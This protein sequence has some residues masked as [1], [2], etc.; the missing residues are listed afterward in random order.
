MRT[1]IRTKSGEI[2]LKKNTKAALA[3]AL[4]LTEVDSQDTGPSVRRAEDYKGQVMVEVH[5]GNGKRPFRLSANKV[6]AVRS[7]TDEQLSEAVG[8][9]ASRVGSAE[10]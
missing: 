8:D 1:I 10:A 4:A 2:D 6:N 9:L 5:P 7:L 3:E